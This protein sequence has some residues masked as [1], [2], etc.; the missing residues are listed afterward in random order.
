EVEFYPTGLEC[1]DEFAICGL[2]R[3]TSP[4]GRNRALLPKSRACNLR[5]RSSPDENEQEQMTKEPN[6]GEPEAEQSDPLGA[7]AMFLRVFDQKPPENPT[8]SKV[9]PLFAS[10]APAPSSARTNGPATTPPPDPVAGATG[11]FTRFFREQ[12][13]KASD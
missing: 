10:T 2:N 4:E 1:G 13:D 11:E 9:E 7:T 12:A 5:L 8:N 3:V 6:P